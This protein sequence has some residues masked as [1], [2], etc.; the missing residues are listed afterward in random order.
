MSNVRDSI[1][2]PAYSSQ[3][4]YVSLRNVAWGQK[5][6]RAVSSCLVERERLVRFAYGNGCFLG[7][8]K[9]VFYLHVLEIQR[10]FNYR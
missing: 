8:K 2:E 1:T 7:Q 3:L 10:Y 4:T 5:V 6:R 9:L